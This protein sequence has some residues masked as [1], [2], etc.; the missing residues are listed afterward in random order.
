VAREKNGNVHAR[1]VSGTFGGFFFQDGQNAFRRALDDI[2]KE[3]CGAGLSEISGTFSGSS[4]IGGRT[5]YCWNGSVVFKRQVENLPGA[6]GSYPVSSGLVTFTASG[7]SPTAACQVSGTKQ[8]NIPPMAGSIGVFGSPPRGLEPYS[9]SI[10]VPAPFPASM[11]VTWSSCADA[12]ANGMR[13]TI[14]VG[15]DAINS[16]QSPLVSEHG[17]TY[18]GSY[19]DPGFQ[20][21]YEWAL[22]GH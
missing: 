1:S 10:H 7:L 14:S 13:E 12:S 5:T 19:D 15:G 2:F 6:V 22:E 9:Y 21:H 4:T 8:F 18:Q 20:A 17:L 3:L 11:E 16:G